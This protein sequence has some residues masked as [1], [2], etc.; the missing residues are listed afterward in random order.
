[1]IIRK[2]VTVTIFVVKYLSS[3][4]TGSVWQIFN[5]SDSCLILSF[6]QLLMTHSIFIFYLHLYPTRVKSAIRV[7]SHHPSLSLTIFSSTPT[8]WSLI[9]PNNIYPVFLIRSA[10]HSSIVSHFVCLCPFL[11]FLVHSSVQYS[12]TPHINLLLRFSC[13]QLSF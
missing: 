3:K 2:L 7:F 13:S 12:H 11:S 6:I 9:F 4:N 5:L 1:M 10:L 8:R